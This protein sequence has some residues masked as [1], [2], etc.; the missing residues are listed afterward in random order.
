MRLRFNGIMQ[1]KTGG[2]CSKCGQKSTSKYNMVASKMF[3]LPSGRTV[4]F[5]AGR[6]EEVSEEDGKFLLQYKY[7]KDGVTQSA[8]TEV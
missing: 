2:G 5:F 4:T 3:I 1:Q 7:A 8:F 6:E